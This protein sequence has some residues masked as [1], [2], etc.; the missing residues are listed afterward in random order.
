[1]GEKNKCININLKLYLL[2]TDVKRRKTCFFFF[3]HFMFWYKNKAFSFEN[4]QFLILSAAKSEQWIESGLNLLFYF[5]AILATK[6]F[7]EGILHILFSFKISCLFVE[8]CV[9][10]Q[11]CPCFCKFKPK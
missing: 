4:R 8:K 9:K 5:V 3:C 6:P 1:M 11:I 10:I 2:I 7:S